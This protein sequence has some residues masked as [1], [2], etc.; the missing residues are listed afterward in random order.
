MRPLKALIG[1]WKRMRDKGR[2]IEME[3][4]NKIWI[5][6]TTLLNPLL[7]WKEKIRRKK[8][9]IKKIKRRENEKKIIFSFLLIG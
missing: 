1:T 9:K 6:P 5:W 2:K 3:N 4:I 7:G 8:M